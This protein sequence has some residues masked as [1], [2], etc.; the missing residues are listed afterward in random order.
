LVQGRTGAQFTDPA[1]G[2][3][4]AAG[5]GVLVVSRVAIAAAL[6]RVDVSAGERLVAFALASYADR[7]QLAFPGTAAASARAGLCRSRYLQARGQLE[8]RGLLEV[9]RTAGGRGCSSTMRLAFAEAGP[10]WEGEINAA[11]F[12]AVLSHSPS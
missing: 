6:G 7:E 5:A 11:L 2:L 9:A 3:D 1:D 8:R 12:E 10:W 4:A